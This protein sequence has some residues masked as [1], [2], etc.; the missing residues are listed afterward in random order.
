MK[1]NL[2]NLGLFSVACSLLFTACK[3]S[4]SGDFET[5]KATGVVYKLIKHNE[6]GTKPVI[7]D[8]ATL[9]MVFKNDKDSVLWSTYTLQRRP[10]DTTR[11]ISIPLRKGFS[12]CLEQGITLMA[13]GD[14]A[15]FKVNADSLYLKQFRQK[16]LPKGVHSGTNITFYVKLLGI[17]T[18][19]QVQQE[20]QQQMMKM[21]AEMQQR[22][23]Q[24]T[25]DI[26]K[27][28][29]DNHITAKPTKD[30][31]FF[32][33]RTAGKGKAIKDG[34][35][36]EVAYTGKLLNGTEFDGSTGHNHGPFKI[37]YGP[38]AQAIRG[39]ILALGEMHQGD[40]ATILIP[41]ALGYV[42]R[43]NGPIPAFAPLIFDMEVLRVWK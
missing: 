16:Q 32:L 3:N 11:G 29:A 42:P 5:D 2:T 19:Q 22:K 15:E 34:D 24:E 36:V 6:S 21:Q 20:Q 9:Q 27:Y 43:G 13:V 10:G 7:G 33:K 23:Q 4:S 30:S 37:Q 17:K 39:W 26:A 35:S 38:N 12:G 28:I 1:F 8:F 18:Q 25:A 31:L 41:S 40:K 14:S